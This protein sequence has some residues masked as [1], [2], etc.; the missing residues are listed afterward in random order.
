MDSCPCP[1]MRWLLTD[2]VTGLASN[3][4]VDHPAG[5]WGRGVCKAYRCAAEM[6]PGSASLAGWPPLIRCGDAT[7]LWRW[8]TDIHRC[9]CL[10]SQ[11]SLAS[12]FT[13]KLLVK[14]R[15]NFAQGGVNGAIFREKFSPPKIPPPP[16]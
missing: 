3:V 4:G 11:Y 15:E 5:V 12:E 2:V 1:Q 10:N 9:T 7:F 8:A 13:V 16:V 14:R 6:H